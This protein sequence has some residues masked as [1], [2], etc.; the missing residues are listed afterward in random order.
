MRRGIYQ[1]VA[2]NYQVLRV[3]NGQSLAQ[4]VKIREFPA[5]RIWW[6]RGVLG[7]ESASC[8]SMSTAC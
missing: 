2:E 7:S 8:F 5:S 4:N 6:V 3:I 1:S